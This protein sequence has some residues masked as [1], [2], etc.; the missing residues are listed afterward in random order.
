[1]SFLC[2]EL[3]KILKMSETFETFWQFHLIQAFL[4]KVES[5]FQKPFYTLF[6][7]HIPCERSK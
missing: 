5:V 3:K 1:M 7:R 4:E 2:N 6:L